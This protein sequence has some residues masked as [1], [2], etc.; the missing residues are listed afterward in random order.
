MLLS[1]KVHFISPIT[2]LYR[3]HNSVITEIQ[4]AIFWVVTA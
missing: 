2:I 1:Q 4:V 3:T